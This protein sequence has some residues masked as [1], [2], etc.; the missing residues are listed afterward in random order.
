MNI[1]GII[2]KSLLIDRFP[3]DRTCI[4]SLKPGLDALLME[5]MS[6]QQFIAFF[7]ILVV[8]ILISLFFLFRLLVLANRTFFNKFYFLQ[9]FYCLGVS[10]CHITSAAHQLVK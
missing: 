9:F 8:I 7:L 4:C 6:T 3:A 2:N 10:R 1:Q 5:S